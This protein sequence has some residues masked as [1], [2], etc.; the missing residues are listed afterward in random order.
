MALGLG[1]TADELKASR[2]KLNIEGLAAGPN[3]SLLIGLRGPIVNGSALVLP[4]INPDDIVDGAAAAPA[5]G[6]PVALNLEGEGI[7]DFARVPS[8]TGRDFYLIIAGPE[9]DGPGFA[10]WRWEGPPGAAVTKVAADFGSLRPEGLLP[11]PATNKALV[12]SDDGDHCSDENDPI[13]TRAFRT[14]EIDLPE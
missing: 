11:I 7:R 9:T 13:A 3:G 14:M 8:K 10:L 12:L 5:F 4:F 1:A 2:P 6:P